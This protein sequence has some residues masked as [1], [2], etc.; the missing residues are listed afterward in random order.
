MQSDLKQFMKYLYAE[1]II[2]SN[3]AED[4]VIHHVS[5][6]APIPSTWNSFEIT[7]LLSAIDRNNPI[8]KRD[9]AMIILALVLGLRI[10]DI[11]TLRFSDFDWDSRKLNTIQN[12][13]GKPLTLPVPEA[14]GWAVIDY[15]RNG[16]PKYADTDFIF[17]RHKAPYTPF[18]ESN[19]L[20]GIIHKYMRKAGINNY[21][22]RRQGFHSLRHTVASMLVEMNTSLP[23]ITNILGHTNSNT[24]AIYLKTDIEELAQCVLSPEVGDYE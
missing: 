11:K 21:R 20:A 15:I 12:K 3:V 9:Y 14:V 10:G 16:R 17:V 18:P 13:T 2:K 7:V 24:T 5:R 8:G 6:Q 1:G 22:D 19:H 4:I 23:V